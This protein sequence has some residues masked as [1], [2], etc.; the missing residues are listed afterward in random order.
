MRDFEEFRLCLRK[1]E[2]SKRFTKTPCV[3]RRLSMADKD[4]ALA[5]HRAMAAGARPEVFVPGSDENFLRIL[6]GDGAA[7]GVLEGRKIV[8][9]RTALFR[10]PNDGPLGLP[11]V[12]RAAFI[13][14]CIVHRD[15]QGNNLQFLTYYHLENFLWEEFDHLYTTVSPRNV[16]S[17]RNVIGCGF[18]A[19][20]MQELYGGHMRYVL[21]KDLKHCPSIRMKRPSGAPI[22]DYPAQQRLMDAGKVGYRLV[23]HISGLW[24]LFG[25]LAHRAGSRNHARK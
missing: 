7:L 14:Y 18:Y 1:K 17:L 10:P 16:F 13:D 11:Q 22:R 5:L 24:M 9:M 25:R 20:Q 19:L 6:D 15:Y 4:E 12:E 23:R 3:M 8:C 21:R 2:K